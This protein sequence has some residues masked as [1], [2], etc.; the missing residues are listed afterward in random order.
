MPQLWLSALQTNP[1]WTL[2]KQFVEKKEMPDLKA[3][4]TCQLSHPKVRV[5][6]VYYIVQNSCQCLWA[7]G[8]MRWAASND[9]LLSAEPG[10]VA[11]RKVLKIFWKADGLNKLSIIPKAQNLPRLFVIEISL[12][13]F[14]SSTYMA[15]AALL[16]H[17][18]TARTGLGQCEQQRRFDADSARH[19]PLICTR[20]QAHSERPSGCCSVRHETSSLFSGHGD[21]LSV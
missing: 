15:S 16:C 20:C 14:A 12:P 4:S 6:I 13:S 17:L 3:E 5:H 11:R 9:P 2:V 19:V 8:K 10:G 1:A 7:S 21:G 18:S